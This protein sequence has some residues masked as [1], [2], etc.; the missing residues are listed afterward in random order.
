MASAPGARIESGSTKPL[1]PPNWHCSAYLADELDEAASRVVQALSNSVS[2][3]RGRWILS[4]HQHAACE[5]TL[6]GLIDDRLET[7]RIDRT[8]IDDAH[9][10]WIID[11]KTSTHEGGSRKLFLQEEKRRYQTPT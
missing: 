3:E 6:S 7:A 2:S 11:Y 5:W 10:R 8:F 1:P 4:A 9:H